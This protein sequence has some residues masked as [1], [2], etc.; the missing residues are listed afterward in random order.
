HNL[1]YQGVFPA[2]RFAALGL[3]GNF[4][5]MH[6]L[7]F[8]GQVSL[9]KA[10]LFYADKLT[11]VSPSY[12]REIQGAEQG[13]GLDGLLRNRAQDLHGILNGVDP[14]IWDPATDTALANHYDSQH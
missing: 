13:C 7:E 9:L 3:P 5:N 2:H 1:A 12:A 11:T 14:A 10:G 4:F 6:G 8:H